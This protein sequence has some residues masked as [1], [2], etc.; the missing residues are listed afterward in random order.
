MDTLVFAGHPCGGAIVKLDTMENV[1]D[2]LV[3]TNGEPQRRTN[4]SRRQI[5]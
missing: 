4:D 2:S 3:E 1:E 5:A